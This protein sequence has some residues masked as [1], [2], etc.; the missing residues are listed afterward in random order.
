MTDA[1]PWETEPDSLDF[2]A[3]GLPCAMRRG[4][5]DVWCGY[6]GV[7]PNHP[8]F[9]LPRNHPLKLPS[10]WFDHR[11]G[12]SQGT[13]P[14]DFF[15]HALAGKELTDHCEICLAFEV[16]GGVTYAEDRLPHADEPDG[17][18]WF[19]FDCGHAGDFQP[20]RKVGVEQVL[21]EMIEHMPDHVREH[22]LKIMRA[23]QKNA[24]YRDQQYV[25][26]ECQSLAAQLVAV[27]AV[28]QRE[29]VDGDT[30]RGRS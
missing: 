8:L 14:V 20:G 7:G 24:V 10:S 6:V 1:R 30:D 26:G 5:H 3:E 18:W 13:G 2:E 16:H 21:M 12:G 23:D 11:R 15:L 9:G 17:R 19:G 25:V 4:R 29:N 28:I 22:M 27:V